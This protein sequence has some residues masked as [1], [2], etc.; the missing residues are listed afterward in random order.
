M[1]ARALQARVFWQLWCP[2][3]RM[4]EPMMVAAAQML[5]SM[6]DGFILRLLYM[7]HSH[8]DV[9]CSLKAQAGSSGGLTTCALSACRLERAR[10]PALD[11]LCA[12][13]R[14]AWRA[15]WRC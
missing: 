9:P 6:L 1:V 13:T 10:I 2:G 11:R 7:Q 14:Q 5:H 12:C 3:S 15:R 8:V 4:L